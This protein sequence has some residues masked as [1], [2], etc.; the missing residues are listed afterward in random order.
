M[1]SVRVQASSSSL[2]TSCAGERR[3]CRAGASR[4]AVVECFVFVTS[5][6]WRI[7]ADYGRSKHPARRRDGAIEPNLPRIGNDEP[8]G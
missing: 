3:L 4:R 6:D 7:S 8:H 1:F 5:E 2:I